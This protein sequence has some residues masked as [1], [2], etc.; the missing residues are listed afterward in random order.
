MIATCAECFTSLQY[1]YRH[2]RGA[3]AFVAADISIARRE[4]PFPRA[5]RHLSRVS[6]IAEKYGFKPMM[7]SDMFF[8][9]AG[10][11]EYYHKKKTLGR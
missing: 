11:G 9:I 4:Q 7:W 1:S 5:V 3:L 10:K 6:Q 2:G 8:C